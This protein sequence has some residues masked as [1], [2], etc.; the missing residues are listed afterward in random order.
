MK[1]QPSIKEVL[2]KNILY[3]ILLMCD[4]VLCWLLLDHPDVTWRTSKKPSFIL[5][6]RVKMLKAGLIGLLEFVKLSKAE[7]IKGFTNNFYR[8]KY[9][10]HDGD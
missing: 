10:M 7:E 3:G 6:A 5:D 9:L 8:L 1:I 4:S 2:K